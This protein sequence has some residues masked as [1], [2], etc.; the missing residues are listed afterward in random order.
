MWKELLVKASNLMPDFNDYLLTKFRRDKISNIKNYLDTL[1]RESV[2]RFDGRL[3]YHGYTVLSPDEQ[4][5]YIRTNKILRK[6]VQIL[7][8]TFELVRYAYEFRGEMQYIHVYVPFLQ[9]NRI[10]LGS[11]SY[12]P[13][14]PEVESGG[15]HR[16]HTEIILKVF[17]APILLSRNT[18]VSFTTSKGKFFRETVLLAKIHQGRAGRSKKSGLVPVILYHLVHMSFYDCM[19]MYKFADG[20]ID[21]VST[22]PDDPDYS[23]IKIKDAIY[24]K[25]ADRALN[26]VYKRRVIASYLQCLA[27]WN[28]FLLRDLVSRDSCEYYKAVL[29]R[30]TY[31]NIVGTDEHKALMYIE[32]ANKHLRTT[33][34]ILDEPARYQLSQIKIV[35]KDIYEFLL[36][37]F[38]NM[39]NWMVDYSPTCLYDKK[40][41]SLDTLLADLVSN[42][43][44]K[45]FNIVNAKDEELT[46]SIVKTY[47]NRA[48]QFE[49]WVGRNPAFRAN[50][51][52]CNDNFAITIGFKR[53]RSLENI[54]TAGSSAKKGKSMTTSLLKAHPSQ[55]VVESIAA[56]PPSA[57]IVS[58]EINPFLI[59]DTNGKIIP[60]PWA[61]EIKDVYD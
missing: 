61:D 9:D 26:D 42:I 47:L 48:S 8:S 51:S 6:K 4:L 18:S 56:L 7:D 27:S 19:R 3:T 40:I 44:K 46:T 1:F 13:L 17:C 53:F 35:T 37:A 54:E 16:T 11:T 10:L 2:M 22:T 39:D 58:G 28:H 24:I 30:L 23:Y 14:F 34:V 49:N 38:Y 43:N 32:N 12:Y 29:G 57:P 33:D 59:I 36:T 25:V 45:L 41:G 55:L 15:L 5:Q 21:I 20:E 31:S 60:P 52:F 50:P